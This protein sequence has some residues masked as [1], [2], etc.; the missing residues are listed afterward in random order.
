MESHDS[1]G[2]TIM[3]KR[4]ALPFIM[5]VLIIPSFAQGGAGYG[6]IDIMGKY[7]GILE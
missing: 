5:A 1:G 4:F 6:A 7:G 3:I 2:K